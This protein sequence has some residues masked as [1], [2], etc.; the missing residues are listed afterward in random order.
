L[1][2]RGNLSPPRDETYAFFRRLHA[3][4]PSIV[5]P[6]AADTIVAGSGTVVGRTTGGG[7]VQSHPPCGLT[8]GGGGD[9]CVNGGGGAGGMIGGGAGIVGGT[10]TGGVGDTVTTSGVTGSGGKNPNAVSDVTVIAAAPRAAVG[11]HFRRLV[12]IPMSAPSPRSRRFTGVHRPPDRPN[13][14]QTVRSGGL[15]R[16]SRLPG[17]A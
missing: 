2:A 8:T 3:E 11:S 9:G 5:S 12:G 6:I 1:P 16:F 13:S 14:I 4:P 17:R 10:N 15:R 7:Q